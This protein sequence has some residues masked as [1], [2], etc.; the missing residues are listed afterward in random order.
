MCSGK[1]TPGKRTTG[2]GKSGSSCWPRTLSVA[3]LICRRYARDYGRKSY[4]RHITRRLSICV[5]VFLCGQKISPRVRV[6]RRQR[7]PSSTPSGEEGF[8]YGVLRT[9]KGS[10]RPDLSKIK[11]CV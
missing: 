3:S 8:T 7:G 10:V 5:F 9:P 6:G 11:E 4:I 1:G 2:R